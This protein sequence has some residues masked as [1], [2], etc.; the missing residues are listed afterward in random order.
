MSPIRNDEYFYMLLAP[1]GTEI[2]DVQQALRNIGYDWEDEASWWNEEVINNVVNTMT[3]ENALKMIVE[4]EFLPDP[5][6]EKFRAL[7]GI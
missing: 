3:K 1:M 4:N 2:G 6:C 5:V 7:F